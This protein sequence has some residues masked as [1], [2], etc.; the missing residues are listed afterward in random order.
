MERNIKLLAVFNFFTDFKFYSAVL[1]LYFAK[2]TGSYTLAM[3]LFSV[4]FISSAAFEIPTGIYS[5]K[6]GRKNTVILGALSAVGFSIFYAI[7]ISYWFLFV[8]AILEGLSRSFYSGN[9]DALLHDSLQSVGR[10]EYYAHY[11][12]RISAM[13]QAALTVGAVVGSVIA[14][15]SFA[16]IMWLSVIPQIVCFVVSLLLVNTPRCDHKSSNIYTHVFLS[17]KLLWQNKKLRLLSTNQILSF[18]IGEATFSFSAAFITTVWPIWAIGISKMISYIGGGVSYWYSSKL[19]KKFNSIKLMLFD[20]IYNR[21]ANFIAV[22]FPTILSPLIMS[23]TSFLYGVTDV[24][25]ND[26][27]QKEFTDAQRATLAS[28]TSL[29]GSL[30]FGF[31]SIILGNVADIYSPATAILFSQFCSLPRVYIMYRLNQH[32]TV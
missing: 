7:G 9:N 2:V 29:I 26:L 3:S 13:F 30:F 1:V 28:I 8:G 22:L 27:M 5:D 25:S 11:L 4:I 31:Y 16:W 6:I 23:T 14:N 21:V 15:W 18:G 10:K 12:G 17:F 20:S 32:K 24:A 19:I